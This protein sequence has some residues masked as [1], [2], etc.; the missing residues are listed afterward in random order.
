MLPCHVSCGALERRTPVLFES[1][2]DSTWPA[3]LE[4][5][6]QLLALPRGVPNRVNIAVHNPTKH[7]VVLGRRT[8]LGGLQLIKS[9]TPFEVVRKDTSQSETENEGSSEKHPPE[10]GIGEINNAQRTDNVPLKTPPVKLGDLTDSQRKLA[11]EM[12]TEEAESFAQNDEDV[13]YIEG[14]Q[15]NL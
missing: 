9:V 7:D 11:M 2:P 4:V 8:T 10:S 5:S 13:G 1:I 12:L 6:E 14:L 3:D 15:M